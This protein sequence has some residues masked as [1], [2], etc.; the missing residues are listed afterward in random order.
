MLP[1]RHLYEEE[2][3][4]R[5]AQSLTREAAREGARG[6]PISSVQVAIPDV[7]VPISGASSNASASAC[8]GGGRGSRGRRGA[9][10]ETD[11]RGEHCGRR[12]GGGDSTVRG[13]HMGREVADGVQVA[14]T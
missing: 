11:L 2:L 12:R 6:A 9:V 5:E 10:A 7:Q 4:L 13:M 14:C 8:G 1:A 3:E